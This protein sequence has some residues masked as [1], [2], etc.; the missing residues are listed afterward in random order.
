VTR[1]IMAAF[2]VAKSVDVQRSNVGS[3]D[4]RRLELRSI[5][6]RSLRS[7]LVSLLAV[8]RQLPVS[9]ELKIA[10]WLSSIRA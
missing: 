5:A 4:P 6:R 2:A 3:S 10:P 9:G 7:G 8:M 1:S